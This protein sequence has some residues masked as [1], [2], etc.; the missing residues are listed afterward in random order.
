MNSSSLEVANPDLI[1]Q[2]ITVKAQCFVEKKFKS[3]FCSGGL[4]FGRLF[5]RE[6]S[7]LVAL[8]VFM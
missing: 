7:L 3:I 8:S 1:T 2:L 4:N 6:Y 5:G